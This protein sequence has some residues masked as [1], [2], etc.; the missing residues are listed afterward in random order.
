MEAQRI[1][2]LKGVGEALAVKLKKLG[3]ETVAD[4]VAYVPRRYEDYS[5]VLRVSQIRP[6]SVTIRVRLHNIKARYSKRGLHITEAMASDDSGSVQVIWFNQ[7]YRVKAIKPDEEYFVSGEFAKNHRFFAITNPACELVSS[8]PVNTAR[9]VPVYRLTKGLGLTQLRKAM[10]AALL[11]YDTPES[12]PKWLIVEQDLMSKSDALMQ[13]HFPESVEK[14]E[15][16][17]KRLGFEEIFELSLASELNKQEFNTEHGLEIPFNEKLTRAFVESL[18]FKLTGD[19]KRAA[20]ESFQDMSSGRPMN[21]LVEG[22]VGS[23]KTVVAALAAIGTINAGFQVAFMAPTELLANQHASTLHKALAEI[24]FHEKMLLLTGSMTAAQKKLANESIAEGSAQLVVGTHALFQESV[25]F[26][27]L[28][29]II[30]DEQHRFGVQQR[31]KLQSKADSMPHVLNLT[32]TPIPRS[33]ALTLYG[34]M[35][36][37]IIAELPEGRKPVKTKLEI[38]ENRQKVY[39]QVAERLD[40][41]QQAFIVCPQIEESENSRLSVKK[42]HEQLQKTWL[43]PY[44]LGL[45]HGKMKAVEKDLVMQKFIDKDYD[46]VVSTT[47]IEV[48]VDVSNATAMVIEGAD[49]FGLAQL[50]QLRGRVGRGELES[51]CY[52]VLSSNDEP[53]TR[54]KVLEHERNGFKLAEYDLQ[55]RGPGAIYGTMQHGELDLRVA[56][57]T[58]VKLIKLAR[59][60]ATAFVKKG[61]NLLKYP[62]LAK[63]VDALRI[64]DNLN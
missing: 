59:A 40:A 58:D 2:N 45:L 23:G 43:K 55:L 17:R 28:G 56:K 62:E 34:E 3:I 27:K 16:A 38:P 46:A 10:R 37:S 35:D 39:A 47:V 5:H 1:T 63:R 61:E 52:L 53:K 13:M 60:A 6:G 32:A 25:K 42:I 48:G 51:V 21:R 49:N 29:L 14:L 41:G 33:L 4:L 22:D 30:V 31:K 20:W 64:I 11:T 18:P 36:I 19:Q 54:L 15:I 8:F 44:R 24:G 12:L 9:L 50:H 57:L 7:P 26:K